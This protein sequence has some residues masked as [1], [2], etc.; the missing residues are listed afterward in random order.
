MNFTSE[1]DL[2]VHI[3]NEA[4]GSDSSEIL[5][6]IKSA[7]GTATDSAANSDT[8]NTGL[9]SLV[10]RLLDKITT[11]VGTATDSA[12]N[13]DTA[14]TGLISLVKR[15]LDKITTVTSTISGNRI[16]V[17]TIADNGNLLTY[18]V[19]PITSTSS[20][21]ALLGVCSEFTLQLTS[22]TGAGTLT[23]F[24]CD[25]EGSVLNSSWFTLASL[26]G[27]TAGSAVS[28]TGKPVTAIR[29]KITS[30]ATSGT[31]TNISLYAVGK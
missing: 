3:A 30:I 2:K 17:S 20:A 29:A 5:N 24:N 6:D 14:N 26:T 27:L 12:A 11:V 28:T 13:S 9:I 4:S 22:I 16:R 19:S 7:V 31:V 10:K 23:S 8:A 18:T 1:G 25:L 15:L 21:V